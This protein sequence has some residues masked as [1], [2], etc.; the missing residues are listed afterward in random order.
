MRSRK[1][2]VLIFARRPKLSHGEFSDP[3]T[4]KKTVFDTDVVRSRPPCH[5]TAIIIIVI[6]ASEFDV[7][8]W[9]MRACVRRS[10]TKEIRL[11]VRE[12][13]APRNVGKTRTNRFLFAYMFTRNDNNDGD[14][15]IA[16]TTFIE[17]RLV[18]NNSFLWRLRRFENRYIT[19]NQSI[20]SVP[21]RSFLITNN[22]I[23]VWPL[24]LSRYP[25]KLTLYS[26]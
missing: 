24:P 3:P 18:L 23:A 22:E 19:L 4:G 26:L 15:H 11:S 5:S 21:H 8:T 14:V 10:P 9:F 6:I 25:R 12:K 2:S 13:H 7:D 1:H 16:N 17:R 20:L